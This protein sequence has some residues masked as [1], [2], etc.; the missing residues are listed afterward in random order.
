[1]PSDLKICLRI[2]FFMATI[3]SS[4]SAFSIKKSPKVVVV[5]AG[6]SGITTA[7][8]LHSQGI[9]VNL[10]EAR[11]RVGGRILTIK[12]NNHSAELGGQN[13]SDGGEAI[14]LNRLI[15]EL[16]LQRTSSRIYFNHAYFN[17]KALIPIQEMLRKRHMDPQALEDELD[18]L[19]L[20]RHNMQ[21]ILEEIVGSQDPLYQ[22]LAARLSA[23]EGGA[24][25]KL[26]PLYTK[27]LFHMLLGGICSAHQEN[28][29]VDLITVAGGNARLPQK[30]GQEL[31]PRLH[32]NMPLTKVAKDKEDLFQLTFQNGEKVQADLLV[33]A[34]PCS[35]YAQIH[36]EDGIIPSQKLEA[37]RNIS[38][39]TNAKILVPFPSLPVETTGLIHGEMLC[40]L[41]TMQH[42]LTVYYT[43]NTSLFSSTTIANSYQQATPMIEKGFGK[44]HLPL[45]A[46]TYAE[47]Q[48]DLSY[49]GPVGYSWPND[50]YARGTYSYIA[51]GQENLLTSTTEQNG[52]TFKTL[53]APIHQKLYFVGEHAS[54]LSEVPGTME[55]ACESGERVARA[56]IQERNLCSLKTGS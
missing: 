16:Q 55:A 28:T 37:I 31:G 46:P 23:Y 2:I 24:I 35:V 51:S 52:E 39:G 19:A 43:G 47:D 6:I 3:F 27:T 42:I 56:I 34:M 53:F 50:P 45:S 13:I 17:G 8:R 25:E 41:N 1:M 9:D 38:Y 26:S 12:I 20:T 5:G 33:L 44:D 15:D 11:G 14:H 48:N 22:V 40:F 7:Y 36:F 54:I 18:T 10:Y 30:M 49:D 29:H 21:E 4:T 32:L